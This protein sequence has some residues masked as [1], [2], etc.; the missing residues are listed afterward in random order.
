MLL[1]KLFALLQHL[2]ELTDS[3]GTG[4]SFLGSLYPKQERIAVRT[5]QGYEEG[6]GFL[7]LLQRGLKI[8]WHGNNV[9]TG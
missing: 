4:F 9:N 5:I 7:V 2:H 8:L 3:F 6:F 1:V